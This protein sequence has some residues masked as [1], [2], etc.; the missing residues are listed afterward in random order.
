MVDMRFVDLFCG[1]GGASQG[2][3]QAGLR[4]VL[5]VDVDK[6]MLGVHELNHPDATHIVAELPPEQPLPLPKAGKWHLHGSPPC[7]KV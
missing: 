7:G 1:I 3:A 5:A 6:F 4:V 2:A